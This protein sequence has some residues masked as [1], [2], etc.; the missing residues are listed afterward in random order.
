[1]LLLSW[2]LQNLFDRKP[3][4]ITRDKTR[5]ANYYLEDFKLTAHDKQGKIKYQLEAKRLDN[6]DQESVAEL[7]EVQ[8]TLFNEKANWLIS[9]KQATIFQADDKIEFFHEVVVTRPQQASQ[10]P[11][12]LQTEQITLH[13]DKELLHTAAH[14]TIISGQTRLES[15]GLRYNSQTGIFE[16]SADVKATYVK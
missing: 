12:T 4:L 2:W 11:L 6:Y 8:T 5:F 15:N 9:A 7:K 1:M 16:L 10:R 13:T 14:V 3:E